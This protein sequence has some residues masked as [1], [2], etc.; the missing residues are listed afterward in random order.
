MLFI[1]EK[2]AKH[3]FT[4]GRLAASFFFWSWTSLKVYIAG[5]MQQFDRCQGPSGGRR[6]PC[7][8]NKKWL[9]ITIAELV[10]IFLFLSNWALGFYFCRFVK[11]SPSINSRRL[12]CIYCIYLLTAVNWGKHVIHCYTYSGYAMLTI[13]ANFWHLTVTSWANLRK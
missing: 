11:M 2:S 12:Y 1:S 5:N 7:S 10:S 13:T 6:L 3:L 8:N 9:A 4:G